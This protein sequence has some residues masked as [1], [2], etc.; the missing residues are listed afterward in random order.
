MSAS[1]ARNGFFISLTFTYSAWGLSPG[2]REVRQVRNIEIEGAM[3]RHALTDEDT[4]V[5]NSSPC[6]TPEEF[7]KD[8]GVIIAFCL[9]L[10]LLMHV[11]LG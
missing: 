2:C 11:L 5:A 7:F 10:G 6:F 1:G 8:A 9:G 3:R 4:I